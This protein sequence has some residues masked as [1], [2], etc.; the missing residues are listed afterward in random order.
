MVGRSANEIGTDRIFDAR[1][2]GSTGPSAESNGLGCVSEA[3][4]LL[5]PFRA[6]SIGGKIPGLRPGRASP[7]AV[8]LRPVGPSDGFWGGE[9]R[10]RCRGKRASVDAVRG[11]NCWRRCGWFRQICR[12]E[13]GRAFDAGDGI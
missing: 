11:G 10:G 5:R 7:R 13:T 6:R 8:S 12:W 3:A 4:F 1:G 2:E 9:D